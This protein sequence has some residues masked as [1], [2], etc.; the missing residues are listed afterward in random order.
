MSIAASLCSVARGFHRVRDHRSTNRGAVSPSSR[1]LT[2]LL[3]SDPGL[4]R[5]HT[6]LRSAFACLLTGAVTIGWT[7]HTHRA[8]TL[9]AFALLFAMV[10]PLFLRD[11]TQRGWFRSL[12]VIYGA[13]SA[14]LIAASALAPWPLVADAGFL[15][16][17]FAAML[18]Q[19]CGPRALGGAMMA[20]VSFYLGLYLHPTLA[21]VF[22]MLGLSA[23]ALVSVAFTG[24]VLVPTRPDATLRRAL[25]AVM[26]RATTVLADRRADEPG[27]MGH[28]SLLNE[29]ALA[30]EEQ[31]GL[32]DFSGAQRLRACLIDVEV[33]AAQ[34]A[35]DSSRL[36]RSDVRLR[37]ALRRLSRAGRDAVAST[38][39]AANTGVKRAT[40]AAFV[41][42]D[43]LSWLPACRA[44]T[45][46]LIAMLIGHSVSPERW[47]WA[48]ITT[49][50]VFLGTRSR[51]DTIRKTGERVLGTLAGVAVSAA[52]VS[53]LHGTP[54][55]LVAAML[56]C[57]FGWAYFILT[58]Y[59]Q[60]V[61]FITV[62]VG[63]IYGELG[64]AIGPL[65]EMR[66][67][68]VFVGCIVSIAVAVSMM[69]LRTSDHVDVKVTGVL[70]ALDEV[71]RVC[72][73]S[74]DGIGLHPLDVVRTLDRRWHE[75]RVALRP[76]QTQRVFAWNTQ[77]ELAVGPLFACVQAARELARETARG[78]SAAATD[79][80]RVRLTGALALFA[81]RSGRNAGGSDA[82][83][84]RELV[85]AQ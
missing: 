28:L 10:A 31:L 83:V 85:A 74:V 2:R 25:T 37:V 43:T 80:A 4:L 27:A 76:L 69:P 50:V 46:A 62:L 60:G 75:L 68:E 57:V 55:L 63:L 73:T 56:A 53:A 40:G 66:V 48:V 3:G 51:G 17:L 12:A 7:V 58:A 59:G 78:A 26:Q 81:A 15:A 11:A 20:V 47:F 19:A 29:A 84:V 24:R 41:W 82:A 34:H 72:T 52:L 21:H 13:G 77:M 14:S 32:L 38:A 45:A 61:F 44:T 1:L 35:V 65:I 64:F 67:E 33:A 23:I 22:T 39:R 5:F 71:L 6:A 30:V 54:W 70:D 42:R 16:V 8:P 18:V 79:E 36:D 9:A 49:F